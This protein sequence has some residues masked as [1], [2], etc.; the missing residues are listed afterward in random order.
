MRKAEG[1]QLV[2][3]YIGRHQ[4]TLEKW[5]A[6]RPIF[7]MCAGDKDYK[8]SGYRRDN[9]WHQE[10][11]GKQIKSILEGLSQEAKRRRRQVDRVTE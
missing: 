6:L 2:M 5:V 9:W 1:T 7:E 3:T 4:A 11:T 10:A 8:G